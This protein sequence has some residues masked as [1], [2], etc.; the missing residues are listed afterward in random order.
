MKPL[1]GWDESKDLAELMNT[2]LSSLL[3][4]C[5]KMAGLFLS[6]DIFEPDAELKG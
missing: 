3:T 1:K 2:T 5:T 6:L 4:L